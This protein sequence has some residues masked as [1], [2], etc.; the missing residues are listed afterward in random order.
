MRLQIKMITVV[1]LT[2]TAMSM[3]TYLIFSDFIMRDF[4]NLEIQDTKNN[5]ERLLQGFEP[6]EQKV[7][8][9]ALDWGQ[10]D[11][12]Y[13]YMSEK[14]KSYRETM[15]VYESFVGLD[16]S[17]AVYY[18]LTGKII[19]GLEIFKDEEKIGP[20]SK[21]SIKV[22]EPESW[23][24]DH[25]DLG[26]KKSGLLWLDNRLLFVASV[27]ILDSKREKP[28]RG[29]LVLATVI[30]ESIIERL[31][32][33]TRL[34]VT[35]FPLNE[36]R[37]TELPDRVFKDVDP[38]IRI[39]SPNIISA[40]AVRR[41]I[42][43][44]PA[45]AL[46]IDRQRSMYAM[47]LTTQNFFFTILL[48]I[49]I[50]S[51]IIAAILL[52]Q[53]VISKVATL[54]REVGEIG[55]TQDFSK[56]TSRNSS[57]ELGELS[58]EFNSML[59]AL[60]STNLELVQARETSEVAKRRAEIANAAKSQFLASVSHELRTPMHGILGL[61]RLLY[62]R[63]AAVTTK[64]FMQM[65]FSTAQGLLETINDLLDLSKAE[66]GK[67][68]VEYA[69]FKLRHMM[70]EVLQAV[71]PRA[72]EGTDVEISCF[73]AP[74]VP[75][76]T[77]GDP[78]RLRQ[79]VMNLLS[80]AIKF[81]ARGEIKVSVSAGDLHNGTRVITFVCQDSGVGIAKDKLSSIFEEY[82]QADNQEAANAKGTGLG[83]SIV[84]QL[85]ELMGGNVT[86]ESVIGVGTKFVVEIPMEVVD[87]RTP[88]GDSLPTIACVSNR[89]TLANSIRSS[90]EVYGFQ[91][92]DSN[93]FNSADVVVHAPDNED[94][95]IPIWLKDRINN[96]KR[97]VVILTPYQLEQREDF[98]KIGVKQ[99]ITC[100]FLSDDLA[101]CLVSEDTKFENSEGTTS[102]TA[103]L[104]K[105]VPQLDILIADDNKTNQII[106]QNLLED[107]G[108]K[109]T[110]VSNGQDLVTSVCSTTTFD[111]VL[112][113]IEMP[114]LDGLSATQELRSRQSKGQLTRHV[115]VVA[116]TAHAFPE[117][118]LHMIEMGVDEVI[119][120]PIDPMKLSRL[121]ET[122][123][124]PT[125][126]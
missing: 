83:L 79:I 61:L 71:G 110:V 45:L 112:T 122:M 58:D 76:R 55:K 59:G 16:L 124:A 37:S 125:Q 23:L 82:E 107:A 60:Q 5:M 63:E 25:K 84:K 10:W 49:G 85:A 1:T 35:S 38:V 41:D 54:R 88:I 4:Q 42:H 70:R 15:E 114:V 8:G 33:Q 22:F 113:D 100:P 57:D 2:F 86:V 24:W 81:T 20:L 64:G 21:S 108:H 89:A 111:L 13:R 65:C 12:T 95:S 53:L 98:E 7:L 72:Y 102:I 28:S 9:T 18:D 44:E 46:K 17:H 51:T 90:L 104:E 19:Y 99:F 77:K 26:S 91:V 69:P 80:N 52:N 36:G 118:R 120:K 106:L 123:F 73:V 30:D 43:G 3:A 74:N 115:P 101:R 109:V 67:L 27:P 126:T 29:T 87:E 11:D 96:G 6:L 119:T 103:E 97:V 78:Y 116:V 62:K 56:R 39:A 93:A 14:N 75:N 105:N 31:A 34:Q 40:Y 121:L 32:L 117:E 68:S 47:A 66:A 92:L 48:T 94:K 50:V